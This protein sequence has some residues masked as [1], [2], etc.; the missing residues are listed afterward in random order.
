MKYNTE[1]LVVAQELKKTRRDIYEVIPNPYMEESKYLY[2]KRVRDGKLATTDLCS[3]LMHQVL[4]D[5]ITDMPY[6]MLSAEEQLT[7]QIS[8]ERLLEIEE[9]LNQPRVM[10]DH[11]HKILR[12]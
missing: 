10:K 4:K 5:T 12:K 9:V 7:R 1:I 8:Y 6:S 2:L 11:P 3:S